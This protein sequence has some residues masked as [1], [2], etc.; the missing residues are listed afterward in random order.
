MRREGRDWTLVRKDNGFR[1]NA[2]W[3]DAA[4]NPTASCSKWT[5]ATHTAA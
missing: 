3:C 4:W 1:V 5:L 2:R